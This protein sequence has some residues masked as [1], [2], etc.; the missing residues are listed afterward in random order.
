MVIMIF[1][2][3]FFDQLA[4]LELVKYLVVVVVVAVV[5]VVDIVEVVEGDIVEVVHDD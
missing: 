3:H 1:V 5:V 4:D 2:H